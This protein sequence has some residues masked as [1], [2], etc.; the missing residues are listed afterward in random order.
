M[1][2]IHASAKYAIT[3]YCD[4]GSTWPSIE[5]HFFSEIPKAI[6]KFKELLD[7]Y[8][9][10]YDFPPDNKPETLA[11]YN[12]DGAVFDLDTDAMSL[13]YTNGDD[14]YLTIKFQRIHANTSLTI[15]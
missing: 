1:A 6:A 10:Q 15:I 9:D 13:Y 3:E 2:N 5:V 7:Q 11:E 8:G 12:S 4:D 14:D